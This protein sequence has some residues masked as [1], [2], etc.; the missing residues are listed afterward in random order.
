MPDA[1]TIEK[2]SPMLSANF[3]PPENFFKN[4]ALLENSPNRAAFSDRMAWAMSELSIRFGVRVKE[5]SKRTVRFG[6]RVE[7]QSKRT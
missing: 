2:S 1:P 4:S 3:E 6:V 7:G 5:Q